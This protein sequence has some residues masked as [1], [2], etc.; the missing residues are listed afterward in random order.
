[1]LCPEGDQLL[2]KL[3]VLIG[4][5][6]GYLLPVVPLGLSLG[7][8]PVGFGLDL[9]CPAGD[10]AFGLG[11]DGVGLGD[12]LSRGEVDLLRPAADRL[13][14]LVDVAQGRSSMDLAKVLKAIRR[15]SSFCWLPRPADCSRD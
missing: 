3:L 4:K 12:S 6:G 13:T 10:L 1:M 5:S 8:E 2:P 14:V 11:G 9:D 7:N 15:S